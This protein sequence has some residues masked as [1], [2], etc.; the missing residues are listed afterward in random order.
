MLNNLFT[1]TEQRAISFQSIWGAGDTLAFTTTAGTNIDENTAMQIS[2]FYS[3]V[4]LISDTIS[5]LPMDTFIRR[6][7]D[8]VPYRPRPEWV[9]KPDIDL[10]R[11]EHFQQV[12]V[13]LL[14]DGNAFIRIYRDNQ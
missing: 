3:C 13:S 10:S 4:L 2:A 12:L 9:M 11:T 1:K 14:I 5:T 8:R 7:G 6:S